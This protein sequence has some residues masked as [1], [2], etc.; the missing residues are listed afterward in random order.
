MR[1]FTFRDKIAVVTGASSGIGRATALALAQRGA[2][3]A[4]AARRVG[5]LEEVAA[6]IRQADGEALVV[7][8]DVSEPFQI[9]NLIREVLSRWGQVDIL[10]SNAGQYIRRTTTELDAEVIQASMRVNF[11]SHLHAVLAAL[12]HM[13]ERRSGHIVLVST[14]NGK[15]GIRP[16]APYAAAKFALN[17]L[18]EVMR[19]ELREQGIAVVLI[20]P[21]RVDTPLIE[22]LKVPWIS[23]KISPQ[24]VA[25]AILRGIE[26]NQAEV[27][28]PPYVKLLYIVNALSPRLGDLIARSFHLQGLET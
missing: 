8:T 27:Y 5:L 1:E 16:D 10:V 19:H 26:R 23:A 7:P 6:Q 15:K 25:K 14:M 11:F 21:G 4:L 18:G 24:A 9:D 20:L 13:L 12:P 28:V 22:N 17:G 3:V 2:K